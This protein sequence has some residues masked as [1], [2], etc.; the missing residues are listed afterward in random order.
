MRLWFCAKAENYWLLYLLVLVS[1]IIL[2]W[3]SSNIYSHLFSTTQGN[4]CTIRW[5]EVS[6]GYKEVYRTIFL[7]AEKRLSINFALSN[8][9]SASPPPR[10]VSL[11]YTLAVRCLCR[12][13]EGWFGGF[14]GGDTLQVMDCLCNCWSRLCNEPNS[15]GL[16]GKTRQLQETPSN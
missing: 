14:Q 1:L 7:R 3:A 9:F 16:T 13:G 6:V 5:K 11:C 2:H 4:Q 15:P 12:Q 8:G 10:S